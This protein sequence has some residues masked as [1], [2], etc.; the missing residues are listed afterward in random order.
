MSLGSYLVLA[1]SVLLHLQEMASYSVKTL[2]L[3]A[4]CITMIAHATMEENGQ[5]AFGEQDSDKCS[6]PV[7]CD[8]KYI[9]DNLENFCE[10]EDNWGEMSGCSK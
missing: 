10:D 2:V 8:C 9:S 4:C 3:A 7:D 1:D 6:R 5:S